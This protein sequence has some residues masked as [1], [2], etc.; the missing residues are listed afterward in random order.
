MLLPPSRFETVSVRR[1]EDS[2][3]RRERAFPL[4]NR[5]LDLQGSQMP[6]T[7][8]HQA[9]VVQFELIVRPMLHF[10]LHFFR[11]YETLRGHSH[12]NRLSGRCRRLAVGSSA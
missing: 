9:S 2:L 12:R 8:Y 5:E 6:I 10:S 3:L 11:P 1:T 4:G 7:A